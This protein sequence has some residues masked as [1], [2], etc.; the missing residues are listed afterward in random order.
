L[1]RL[2]Q[3]SR[4]YTNFFQS[5]FKLKSKHREGARVYKSYERPETPSQ[6]L[7]ASNDITAEAKERLQETL[8][9]LDPVLVLKQIREAQDTLRALSQNKTPE[10]VARDVKAFVDSLAT[11]WELG[12]YGPPTDANQSRDAGGVVGR[13]RLPK[14][15]RSCWAGCRR[16]R[17][18][19]PRRC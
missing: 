1:R 12:K 7:L 11:A 13:T 6:R 3:S 17:T 4:L 2:Y 19:K 14:S 8:E 9:G 5:C 10:V 18:W 15:G 16:G